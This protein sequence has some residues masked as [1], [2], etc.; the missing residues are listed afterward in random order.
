[1]SGRASGGR[2]VLFATDL[3]RTL[4]YSAAAAG[5]GT[6]AGEEDVAR[7]SPLEGAEV[8]EHYDGRAISYVSAG[9]RE[10]LH[11][12]R[13]LCEVVPVTTRTLAQYER[14]TL[15]DPAGA[16][17]AV[18]ANG[19]HLLFRGEID[20]GW[21]RTVRER[22]AD[23][24]GAGLVEVSAGMADRIGRWID[25][26]RSADGYFA[27]T[28]VDRTALPDDALGDLEAWLTS[29]GWRVSVQGRKLYA[30]PVPLTKSAAVAALAGRLEVERVVAAGDSLL[31]RDL[32]DAADVSI[33]P[34]HGE[35][36]AIGHPTDH[37]T[38]SAGIGAG[39]EILDLVAELAAVRPAP[40]D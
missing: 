20:R 32:L 8:V 17:W 26:V 11:R 6:E 9:F 16:T 13:S 21:E 14:I 7:R 36:A 31:D 3:D 40:A 15:F 39:E 1:M 2:G 24:V 19:G 30:V 37:V 34:A 18:A 5:L 4:I 33:R 25:H 29:L 12:L 28:I 38:R 10:R 35:L 22:V 27:Y 23:G